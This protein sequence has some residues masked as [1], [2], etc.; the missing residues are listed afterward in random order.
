MCFEIRDSVLS[1]LDPALKLDREA[2]AEDAW[3]IL[4]YIGVFSDRGIRRFTAVVSGKFA[5]FGASEMDHEKKAVC[6][7][8][9]AVRPEYRRQGIGAA[10]LKRMEE[11]FGKS[12][13]YLYA[14]VLNPDAIRLYEKAGYRQTGRIQA[15]YMNG[16][17][18]LIM[19]KQIL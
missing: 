14:D 17:D 1:D 18:A 16:H 7:L 2:F 3:T 10:L 9:L 4:D 5:G 11:A 8:T 13:V 15:Y 19:E 6:L 12:A